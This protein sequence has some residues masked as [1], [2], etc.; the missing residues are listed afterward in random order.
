MPAVLK[1]KRVRLSLGLLL[2]LALA[3]GAVAYFTAT[4]SGTGSAS[5]GTVTVPS[6]VIHP[7]SAS[8]LYPGT[9]STVSFKVDNPSPGHQYMSTI[10]LASV[11]ACNPGAWNGTNCGTG[12]TEVACET[13]ETGASDTN[14]D[15]FWMPDVTVDTDFA[16]G[17]GQTV[18]PTSGTP[19]LTMNDLNSSQNACEGA[20]LTLNFTSS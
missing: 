7:T 14:T 13:V 11:K 9:S 5:V 8:T 18:T 16:S 19:T 3:G 17:N 10:H 1:K 15:D 12:G 6:F 20:N 4:G 2:L